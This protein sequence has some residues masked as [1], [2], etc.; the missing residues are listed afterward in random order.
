V[1]NQPHPAHEQ[2]KAAPR[3]AN[4]PEHKDGPPALPQA[5]V[6][7]TGTAK[8]SFTD[9]VGADVPVNAASWSSSSNLT[10]KADDK[11]PTSAEVT[12]IGPGRAQVTVNAETSGGPAT[13]M[14]EAMIIETGT[15]VAGKLELT[16]SPPDKGAK[17]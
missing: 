10:V 8:V 15:P 14:A 2:P 12:A 7:S 6:G 17:K 5:P 13:A 9:T 3:A 11:D 1:A 16:L 4:A